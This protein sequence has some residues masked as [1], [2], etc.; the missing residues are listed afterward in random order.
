MQIKYFVEIIEA[1]VA[2]GLTQ[3]GI[4]AELGLK[5]QNMTEILSKDPRKRRQNL[6]DEHLPGLLRLC[7]KHGIEPRTASGLIKMIEGK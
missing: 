5:K 2:K 7:R 6:K 1:L 4:A 3:Q